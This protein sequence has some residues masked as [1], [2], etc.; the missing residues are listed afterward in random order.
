MTGSYI[1]DLVIKEAEFCS[2]MPIYTTPLW[3][4]LKADGLPQEIHSNQAFPSKAPKWNYPIRLI[5]Q[6]PDVQAAYLY[7]TLCTFQSTLKT[8]YAIARSRIGLRTLPSGI[9]RQF[10]FPL[11]LPNTSK[12]GVYLTM[13][14]SLSEF[15]PKPTI[16]SAGN[17]SPYSLP[18]ENIYGTK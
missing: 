18:F 7:V 11:M 8:V 16:Y 10:K 6:I 9:P 4:N 17:N 2:D 13:V 5:L 14:A 1:L 15:T 3:L 12:L